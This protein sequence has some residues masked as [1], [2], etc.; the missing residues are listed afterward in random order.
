M[1]SFM[2]YFSEPKQRGLSHYKK[3]KQKNTV[4]QT[5]RMTQ[6]RP[7]VKRKVWPFNSE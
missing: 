3:L 5:Y 1:C 7:Q 6:Q 4:A 2:C